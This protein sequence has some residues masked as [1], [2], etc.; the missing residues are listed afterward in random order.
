M[1]VR[2]A[3]F[4]CGYLAM[5]DN[6]RIKITRDTA[7]VIEAHV[8]W[9]DDDEPKDVQWRITDTMLP[10]PEC[11]EIAAYI[12]AKD[13]LDIRELTVPRRK[14]YDEW[15]KERGV[16]CS[17]EK[18]ERVFDKLVN[19][20]IPIVYKGRETDAF[21]LDECKPPTPEEKEVLR[22]IRRRNLV[23]MVV[24]VLYLPACILY[25]RFFPSTTVVFAFGYVGILGIL[26]GLTS[27]VKCPRCGD[28]FNMRNP[29]K[30]DDD[31]IAPRPFNHCQSCNLHLRKG[32]KE[33]AD[34]EAD[35][36]QSLVG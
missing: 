12:A 5:F 22:R 18:F 10:D 6:P 17:Y 29:W 9:P 2:R 11:L 34:G 32:D 35:G 16:T 27:S 23:T 21:F 7:D 25:S 1:A 19:L 30:W 26:G 14:V 3:E 20:K 4:L 28:Y 24:F 33:R 8:S 13:L 15:V 31:S 36:V